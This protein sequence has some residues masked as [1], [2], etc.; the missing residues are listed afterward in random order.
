MAFTNFLQFKC[1]F[2]MQGFEKKLLASQ[3]NGGN[4]GS[5]V[6]PRS[7]ERNSQTPSQRLR[8]ISSMLNALTLP[9]TAAVDQ[10]HDDTVG[11]HW[12]SGARNRGKPVG[13]LK[14]L[15]ISQRPKS[16]MLSKPR[17]VTSIEG[18]TTLRWTNE[19]RRNVKNNVDKV[20]AL[21]SHSEWDGGC[22]RALFLSCLSSNCFW[23]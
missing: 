4:I 23:Q 11:S 16:R 14:L 21:R 1:R 17:D 10:Y 3:V 12:E 6:N 5:T 22:P 15:I 13:R 2:Y 8:S 18:R 20:R 7:N 19:K 9:A